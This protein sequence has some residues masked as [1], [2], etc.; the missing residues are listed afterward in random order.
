[1]KIEKPINV[2]FEGVDTKI[3]NNVVDENF[4]LEIKE[5]KKEKK[6]VI[7]IK[8]VKVYLKFQEWDFWKKS[9][10][11]WLHRLNIDYTG[12]L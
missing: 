4:N 11:L 12:R 9:W 1:M 7:E 6:I 2:L 5:V 8:P 10:N 3:Y